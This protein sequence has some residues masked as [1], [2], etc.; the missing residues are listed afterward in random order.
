M[1]CFMALKIS[2]DGNYG[3]LIGFGFIESDSKIFV[4]I[5]YRLELKSNKIILNIAFLE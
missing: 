1:I 3:N 2:V 5:C 4:G